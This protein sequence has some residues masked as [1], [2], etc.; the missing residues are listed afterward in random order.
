MK[1]RYKRRNLLIGVLLY[2]IFNVPYCIGYISS[3]RAYYIFSILSGISITIWFL[4]SRA[5]RIKNDLILGIKSFV[6]PFVLVT[7]ISFLTGLGLYHL[8][9]KPYIAQAGRKSFEEKFG[10]KKARSY[11]V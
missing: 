4:L 5:G 6:V 2:F 3:N 9:I 11:V 8:P 10:V 7:G 1:L